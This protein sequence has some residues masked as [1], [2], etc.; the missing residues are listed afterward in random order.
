MVL[1]SCAVLVCL[2]FA[3]KSFLLINRSSLWA[4]EIWSVIKSFQ[5]SPS[6]IL[7]YLK[8]DSH[9]PFYYLSLWGWGRLVPQTS[10]SL[11]LF[12]WLFYL[13]GGTLMVVQSVGLA[14]RPIRAAVLAA[15]MA[16]CTPFPVRYSIEGKGYAF[17][18]ALLALALLLRRIILKSS[19]LPALR[20]IS[21]R[22]V[23]V[24]IGLTHF[25]G[26]GLIGSMAIWD[27]L[28]R[29]WSLAFAAG[30]GCI[31]GLAWFVY[32]SNHLLDKNS[33]SWI[34]PPDLSLLMET[35]DRGMGENGIWKLL[36]LIL[37]IIVLNLWELNSVERRNSER[38]YPD[39]ASNVQLEWHSVVDM[40]GVWG[41]FLM[42][43]VVVSLS[44]K[45]P[46]AY[47]RYFIVIV[48][49]LVPALAALA[50]DWR[51]PSRAEWLA[52]AVLVSMIVY[53]WQASFVEISPSSGF[54]REGDDYQSLSLEFSDHPDR[55]AGGDQAGFLNAVDRLLVENGQL[56]QP[57]SE[58]RNKHFLKAELSGNSPPKKIILVAAGPLDWR[59]KRI[60]EMVDIAL[61]NGYRCLPIKR[62]PEA[63]KA[64]KCVLDS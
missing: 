59:Q 23:A 39:S 53:F 38:R 24:L 26:L 27:G 56:V 52:L 25:Y 37:L 44:F 4:D 11:R 14:R 19:D 51:L 18:L 16:F 5:P 17:L 57:Q 61:E 12:S 50:A 33:H 47:S 63:T 32:S 48:P 30:I 54:A 43:L 3:I 45:M 31:P 7:E 55:F 13:I 29:R 40:S 41:A 6:F 35:L 28:R 42:V 21:Y 9:P 34:Q 46:M 64:R 1:V 62:R 49:V 20:I 36:A 10:F 60:A 22:D 2:A 8:T 58:W 15:L